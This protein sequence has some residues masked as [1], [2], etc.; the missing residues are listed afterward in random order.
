MKNYGVVL[1]MDM[2]RK[3]KKIWLSAFPEMR[4]FFKLTEDADWSKS[5]LRWKATQLGFDPEVIR[6]AEDLEGALFHRIEEK[7]IELEAKGQFAESAALLDRAEQDAH[8]Q[9]WGLGRY[10][11]NTFT[12][13]T[14]RNKLYNACANMCFQGPCADAAK[15]GIFELWV[16]SFRL[17]NFIHDEAIAEIPLGPSARVMAQQQADIFVGAAQRLF[18]HVRLKAAPAIMLRWDKGAEECYS[19]DGLLQLWTPDI[20]TD[21]EAIEQLRASA[22]RDD[23]RELLKRDGGLFGM[24]PA[25][26]GRQ[27]E[28]LLQ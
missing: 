17:V 28:A 15:L 9:A 8:D 2:A 20:V 11:C 3:L 4:K 7:A 23:W 26:T 27:C 12:G 22:R 5:A 24:Q 1:T 19:A 13:R 18:Q 10:V 6:T 21:E 25:E 14:A 16:N